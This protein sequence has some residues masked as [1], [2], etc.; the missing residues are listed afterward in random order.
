LKFIDRDGL[1]VSPQN[2]KEIYQIADN[3]NIIEYPPFDNFGDI[4]SIP[5]VNDIHINDLLKLK[6]L[7]LNIVRQKHFKICLDTVNGA[8]GPIMKS[9]LE[10]LGCEVVTL[11]YETTG[12]FSHEPEP[13]PEHLSQLCSGVLEHGA[14]FGIATDPDVDRCVFIDE[15]GK[16]IGEE[17]T[18]AISVFY[19][20]KYSGKRGPVCK[21]LST[22]RAVDDIANQFSCPTFATPVGEIHVAKKMIEVGAVIGGEG[23]GGVMLPDLHIG[24]DALVAAT[25]VLSALAREDKSMSQ[26]KESLPKWII[27]KK[28]IEMSGSVD[29]PKI[30][31]NIQQEYKQQEGTKINDSDGIRIDTESWW[32]HFRKSNTE[33]VVRVISESTTIEESEYICDQ[34][35]KKNQKRD[36]RYCR[37]NFLLKNQTSVYINL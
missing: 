1:F 20:L 25:L 35:L 9:L 10:A 29:I 8:G 5:D 27:T 33:P 4:S 2:C 31:S 18:L 16:P 23:N 15:N 13:I 22:S 37:M 32:V 3:P 11:N 34:F 36:E 7:D 30:L 19:W 28:K 14:Q 12:L 26:L 21:N 24:R 6:E 17:Y